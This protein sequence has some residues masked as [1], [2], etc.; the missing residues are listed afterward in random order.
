MI[1]VCN[2]EKLNELITFNNQ[3]TRDPINISIFFI[4]LNHHFS[5]VLSIQ[6]DPFLPFNPLSKQRNPTSKPLPKK[7]K[8]KKD[9]STS[10]FLSP[11]TTIHRLKISKSSTI[12]TFDSVEYFFDYPFFFFFLSQGQIFRL[13]I[14]LLFSFSLTIARNLRETTM[15]ARATTPGVGNFIIQPSR[16]KLFRGLWINYVA[17]NHVGARATLRK[18]L[19][20][21]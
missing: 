6:H 15:V 9:L 18:H 3:N 5:T 1:S 21:A 8:K 17:R 12:F 4:F 14:F 2:N 11:F 19:L 20:S 7:K 13:F 10:L 16:P